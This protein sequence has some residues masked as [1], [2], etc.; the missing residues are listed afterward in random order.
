MEN[1]S[2]YLQFNFDNTNNILEFKW[3][4]NTRVMNEQEFI[5][6]INLTGEKIKKYKDCNVLLLS[7]EMKFAIVPELQLKANEILLPA[8]N[9][10]GVKKLAVIIPKELISE[11][12]IEQ[13]IE[14][15]QEEHVFKTKFYA[16][17]TEARKW[18]IEKI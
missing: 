18:L 1:L 8:Y 5:N 10:S 9:T 2:K 13:T 11:M 14:E 4:E 12:S 7:Q 6:E 3:L 17:K 16:D 15:K